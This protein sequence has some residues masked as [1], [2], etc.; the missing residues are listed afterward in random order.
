MHPPS[1]TPSLTPSHLHPSLTLTPSLSHSL[2]FSLHYP[3]P[4]PLPP[5]SPPS[6]PP[7]FTPSLLHSL[8]HSLP[9]SPPLQLCCFTMPYSLVS[10]TRQLLQR[11][12]SCLSI[13][14]PSLPQRER[15]VLDPN[16][17]TT[18]LISILGPWSLISLLFSHFL[19]IVHLTTSS[20]K[21]E[22]P[23]VKL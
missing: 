19:N 16:I 17:A 18:V 15:L 1:F 10:H 13:P 14:S 9:P 6:P 5:L 20:Y 7:T 2:T 23:S 22:C 8:P 3:L 12:A 21:I 11:Q 4:H